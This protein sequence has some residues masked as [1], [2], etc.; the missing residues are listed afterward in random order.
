[1]I[2]KRF[3]SL[4]F[5]F[6]NDNY[7]LRSVIM[8]KASD[9]SV[10]LMASFLNAS[11]QKMK[12]GQLRHI[13]PQN[14]GRSRLYHR[15]QR[16]CRCMATASKFLCFAQVSCGQRSSHI[17]RRFHWSDRLFRRN[18]QPLHQPAELLWC[19]GTHFL[20]TARPLETAF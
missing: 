7:T 19:Q 13:W 2:G 16:I 6:A 3:R 4:P 15:K 5:I 14:H 17:F 8:P 18:R 12:H 11:F 20:W 9:A 1:M 10:P